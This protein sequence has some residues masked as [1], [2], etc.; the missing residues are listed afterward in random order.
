MQKQKIYLLVPLCFILLF[1]IL[2]CISGGGGG[3]NFAGCVD[4]KIDTIKPV[5]GEV[6]VLGT[7]TNNC[8]QTVRYAKIYTTCYSSTGEVLDRDPEYVE[9]VAPGESAYFESP[10]GA[11]SSEVDRC[12]SEVTEVDG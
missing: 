10:L 4:V 2:A 3:S 12:M 5:A 6:D 8:S 9:N 7:F 11:S 1:S